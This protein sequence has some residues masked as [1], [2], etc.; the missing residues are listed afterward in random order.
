[1]SNIGDEEDD[2]E[3]KVPEQNPQPIP[4]NKKKQG[5]NKEAQSEPNREPIAPISQAPVIA[6]QEQIPV[7]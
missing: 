4:K 1:M 7:N 3:V 6:E 5:E 2:E